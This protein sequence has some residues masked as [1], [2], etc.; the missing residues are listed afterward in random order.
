MVILCV[1]FIFSLESKAQ[2]NLLN[3]VVPVYDGKESTALSI[4]DTNPESPDGKNLCFIRYST[5]VH[6]GHGGPVVNADVMIKN[7]SSGKT[8]KIY[9]V[10][11]TNHNGVN[12]IWVNDSIVAFQVNHLKDFAV[13]NISSGKSMFGLVNGELGHKS[14]NNTIYYTVCNI[15]LRSLDSTR[16]K[17]NTIDE[18]IYRL[19]CLTGE[20]KQFVTKGDIV[21]A[22]IAQNHEI[23]GN[24]ATILHVEPNPKGDKVLFDYRHRKSAGG[25]ELQGFVNADGTGIRWIPV[26][27]M[28][29]VWFDN[30]SMFGVDTFDPEKK[31][32]RFDL[33]GNKMEMLG[34]TSTHVGSSPDRNWYVGE[35]AYYSPEKDG[36]TR[37][38][39][40]KRGVVKPVALLSE[41][42]NSKIT[43]T[44]VAHVNPSFSSDGK[45]VY[46]IRALNNEDKFEAVCLDLSKAKLDEFDSS[47][48]GFSQE[49]V[50]SVF[51]ND[52]TKTDVRTVLKAIADWQIKTPLTHNLADWTNGALYAGMVEWAG[53]AD[54]E[55]YY[56]WLKEISEK[57]NWSYMVNTNPLAKYHADD[58]CVGQ[59]YVELYRKYKDKRMIKPM[60]AY[61]EQILKAPA[62]GDLKFVNTDKYWAT[63]RWSWCDALFMGPTVW[64]KMANVTGNKK[65]LDF[66]YREYKAT[67]DYLYDK[68][69]DLYFRD[70]NYFTKK[71]ANGTKIFWGR[72]NGW[73]FAGLPVIIDELPA[74]YEHKDY[75]VSIYKKMAVRLLSLQSAQGCWHAS[76]LDPASYP[77]PE[78]SATAFYVYG[79]AWGVNNGYLDKETYLPA[80]VNGWKSMVAS[81]GFDGKVGFIQPIGG[82]P[83]HV[84]REMTEVYGVG[85]F[86]MAGTEISRLLDKGML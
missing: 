80:I 73:V 84:T 39:L 82:D 4:F 76:L 40:Y 23:T 16:T 11:T 25:G 54:D 2:V 34:G 58:Y 41:W 59:V 71:E 1:G 30:N 22:F 37:V 31:I 68:D 26:R 43:W 29:V 45:R 51:K 6:G 65:Y 62:T 15:R 55:S 81:V 35:S 69:E 64:A 49:Q 75:F 14:F 53:I 10:N 78:I 79:L 77:N 5:I 33:Q 70:S 21:K 56:E 18:G 12:A 17:Y 3:K 32:Y 52:L 36:F 19:N 13:Y 28:H 50:K 46:F 27:P 74:K 48:I 20:K 57:N 42:N 8:R 86:L 7:I 44:W 38:Y 85:G 61:F 67:T 24:R 66:M 72:G 83:K 9:D 47:S 63:Q 60:Q